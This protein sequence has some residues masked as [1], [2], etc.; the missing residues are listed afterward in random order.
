MIND[1]NV[2]NLDNLNL[3]KTAAAPAPAKVGGRALAHTRAPHAHYGAMDG[4][5]DDAM[6][7]CMRMCMCMH[8]HMYMHMHMHMYM[9]MYML[10]M[11]MYIMYMYMYMYMY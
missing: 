3:A 11:Y 1:S 7:V 4:A 2:V 6:C 9:Y 10:Y 8:M 5:T